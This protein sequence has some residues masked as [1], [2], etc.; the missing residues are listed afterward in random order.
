MTT[1]TCFPRRSSPFVEDPNN[2]MYNN[3]CNTGRYI[4]DRDIQEV[5][6]FF[7]FVLLCAVLCHLPADLGSAAREMEKK[8]KKN[9]L[10]TYTVHAHAGIIFYLYYYCRIPFC[11]RD[12]A[13]S[14]LP[15]GHNE[16]IICPPR[17]R[18]PPARPP[19]FFFSS[20]FL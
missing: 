6:F 8:K 4:R 14:A 2:I 10:Y 11:P 9:V 13:V 16:R 12:V 5:G 20:S 15:T 18:I 1:T 17:N 19:F 7:S 3:I